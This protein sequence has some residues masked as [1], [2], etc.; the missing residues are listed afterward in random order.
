MI[1]PKIFTARRTQIITISRSILAD[2]IHVPQVLAPA[3]L[4]L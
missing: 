4:M 1:V 2:S 3:F